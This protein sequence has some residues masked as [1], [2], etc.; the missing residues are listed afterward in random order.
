MPLGMIAPNSP[1]GWV[2][3]CIAAFGIGITK[4]G[5]SGVSMVHVILFAYVFGA[6]DS[7]GIVLPM[8]IAGDVF[9][10]VMYGKHAN[11]GYVRR[12]MPPALI[13]V[14]LGWFLMTRLDE[15]FFRPLIGIIILGLTVLQILR[16][17]RDDL[18]ADVPHTAWFAWSMGITVGFTTMLA[19]AAGPV[20]GLYLL[21]IGL[22][23]M[24]FV[25][26]AAWFFLILNVTKVPFSW[27]LGLIRTDTL[28]LNAILLPLIAVGLWLGSLIVK[29]IPQKIFDSMILVFTGLAALRMLLF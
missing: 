14:T 27:N 15:R 10:M 18:I 21:A 11:W 9:A 23:K 19:N 16:L 7:T 5:F 13:G 6:R 20:F 29:R 8:L 2:L 17:W 26:T 25:G 28:A 22:P 3:L 1:I 24:E 12:M 4:S